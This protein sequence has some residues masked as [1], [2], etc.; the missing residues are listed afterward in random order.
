MSQ[1]IY[2]EVIDPEGLN[3]EDRVEMVVDIYESAD[4]HNPNTETEKSNTKRTLQRQQTGSR[5]Y[6]L[7]LTAVCLGLLSVLLLI[8]TIALCIKFSKLMTVKEQFQTERDAL[9]KKLF[10][11]EKDIN[12]P[13]WRYFNYS[14]YYISTETKTWS[15]SR[16][17]CRER[18]A[19]LLIINSRE[20]QDFIEKFR[21]GQRSWIGLT[22]N[23]TEGVWKWVDG[24]ALTTEFWRSG[25]PNGNRNEDCV[26]TGYASDPVYSWA[27]FSCNNK[28]VWTCEKR[29]F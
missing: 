22:D 21:R 6:R 8:A 29:I 3:S 10:Q 27:D 1:S 17:D 19:D 20:E 7:T 5:C 9:Q 14:V 23:E 2:Y 13:E 28:F 12:K 25:E 18:G 15:E 16:E 24:S 4:A 11:L 26:I